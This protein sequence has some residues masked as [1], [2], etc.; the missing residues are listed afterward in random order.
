MTA[1][2]ASFAPAAMAVSYAAGLL[3]TL[4]PCVL[5]LLPIVVGGAM[6]AHRAAPLWMG[7]G[8]TIS[9][10]V[11]GLMLGALGPAMGIGAE[12]L[13][14]AA[15]LSLIAFG[16]AL[17]LDRLAGL[18]SRLTQP[19]A[20]SADRLAGTV[21]HQSP[22]AALFFGGLLGLAWSP[23]AGPMLASALA[24]VASGRDGALGAL[25]LGL[26]GF[27]AATPLVIAAYASRAGFSRLTG[28]ALMHSRALRRSFGGVAVV[29]GVFIASGLDR[30]IA[31]YMLERM[32]D[33]WLELITRI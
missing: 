11:A 29:S 27:G 30:H 6:Q 20:L 14:M 23:C 32:P 12:Q 7:A 5:P 17:W 1:L 16:L 2:A 3:T 8:M 13:H 22:V 21:G 9:F 18:V 19:L 26:F 25:L 15:A 4:S 31:T 24:L 33:T 28:W 10:T